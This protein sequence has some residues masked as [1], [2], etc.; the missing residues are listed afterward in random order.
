MINTHSI[1]FKLP[2]I[3]P[4]FPIIRERRS[5]PKVKFS[6]TV[7]EYPHDY[8]RYDHSVEETSRTGKSL[9]H[10]PAHSSSS[11]SGHGS[12]GD[13]GNHGNS[14]TGKSLS[15]HSPSHSAATNNSLYNSGE[16]SYNSSDAQVGYTKLE[17]RPGS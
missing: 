4:F 14:R 12:S 2:L 15:G 10:S 13:H 3:I 16:H 8:G 17:R 5:A 11:S 1:L 6:T 9:G 7:T